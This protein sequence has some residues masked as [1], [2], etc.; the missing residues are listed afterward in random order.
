VNEFA[1]SDSEQRA[2][3]DIAKRVTERRRGTHTLAYEHILQVALEIDPRGG[4]KRLCEI[5]IAARPEDFE[6]DSGG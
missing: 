3:R 6:E 4:D 5:R 1:L 2:L